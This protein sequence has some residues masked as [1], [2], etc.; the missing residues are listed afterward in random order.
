ME[1]I[2]LFIYYDGRWNEKKN[3]VDYKLTGIVAPLNVAYKDLLQLVQTKLDL[4]NEDGEI[5]MEYQINSGSQR[6]QLQND[7]DVHFYSSLKK[8]DDVTSFPLC[9]TVE[10]NQN[11]SSNEGSNRISPT[12]MLEME[13]VHSLEA[14]VIV[15]PVCVLGTSSSNLED[16]DE[17]S[18]NIEN[19]EGNKRRKKKKKVDEIWKKHKK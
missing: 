9:I 11:V 8:K 13:E 10:T 14:V 4:E 1:E 2:N 19:P 7:M 5:K 17:Q 18:T 3:Y 15:E 12:N 16:E 6:S